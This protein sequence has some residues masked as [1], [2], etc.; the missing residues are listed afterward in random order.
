M[1]FT[2]IGVAPPAM[3]IPRNAVYW[4]PLVFAPSRHRAAG[5]RRAIH[6]R[7]GR[8]RSDID[9]AAANSAMATV[10]N[11]LA[12]DFPRTNQGRAM[13]AVR[14]QER[15]VSGIR[16]RLRVLLGAVM[17]V[18]LIACVNVA[19][20]LLARAHGRTREVAVRAALGAGR[21]RLIQ[22]FLA[23]SLVLGVGGGSRASASRSGRRAPS[24]RSALE[25]AAPR[26]SRARLAR[27]RVHDGDRAGDERGVRPGSGDGD[28]RPRRARSISSAGRGSVGPGG[29]TLRKILVTAEFA[30]AVVLLAGAGCC[31]AAISASAPSIPVRA[32]SRAHVQSRAAVGEVRVQRRRHRFMADYVDGSP[33]PGVESAAAV[34]GLPLADDFSA[35]SSFTEPGETDSASSPSLGMRVITPDYFRR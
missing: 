11:R 12:V 9:L 30:L 19:N 17:V 3:A 23:E 13:T 1:P 4:R 33:Q 7:R 5:A 27:A 16:P 21:R 31:C 35:S 26:G 18:L 2:V 24:S 34:F 25:R 20:L 29:T 22:Q 32:R 8:L 15:M 14:M 28:R 10:A 6:L